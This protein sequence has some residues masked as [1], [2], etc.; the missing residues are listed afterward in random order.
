MAFR[1]D[2]T[3]L[4]AVASLA[5]QAGQVKAQETAFSQNLALKQLA[6]SDAARAVSTS[7]QMR[8][9]AHREKAFQLQI[10]A[11]QRDAERLQLAEER[12][13]TSEERALVREKNEDTRL[14][15]ADRRQ[16]EV[17]RA[18]GVRE[19]NAETSLDIR[20]QNADAYQA[21]RIR[22]SDELAKADTLL[23]KAMQT[24]AQSA[25]EDGPPRYE[26]RG[27]VWW[28]TKGRN[29]PVQDAAKI[30]ELN[31]AKG[32]VA[33]MS[34]RSK[35]LQEIMAQSAGPQPTAVANPITSQLNQ[36]FN[37]RSKAEQDMITEARQL[38]RSDEDILA[39]VLAQ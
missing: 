27:E 38:G 39:A 30:A 32:N 25:T 19:K 12:A 24:L 21:T 15:L 8:D 20:Q 28:D 10:A 33:A 7:L 2:W 36:I 17:E 13:K 5:K 37:S 6:D 9:Q 31:T 26:L 18:A 34:K 11:A 14:N 16:T 22:T 3:P 4:Q 35:E 29:K 1:F 23:N